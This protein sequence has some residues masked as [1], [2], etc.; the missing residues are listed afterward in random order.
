[1]LGGLRRQS[2]RFPKKLGVFLGVFGSSVGIYSYVYFWLWAF[3]FV[4]PA[5]GLLG[6][7]PRRF[8]ISP[9]FNSV[10]LLS[11]GGFGRKKASFVKYFMKFPVSS[12]C[13]ITT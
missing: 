8:G 7:Y 13:Q 9:R 4:E 12:C 3:D 2:E 5:I 11:F 1:M 10:L 6:N